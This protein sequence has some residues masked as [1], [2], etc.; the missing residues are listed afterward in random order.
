MITPHSSV[1]VDIWH[2]LNVCV[3]PKF[4]YWNSNPN[5]TVLGGG[6]FAKSL[7]HENGVLMNGISALIEDHPELPLPHEDI[8]R[9]CNQEEGPRL[10]MLVPGSWTC[11]LQNCEEWISI[12]Y[13]LPSLWYLLQQPSW[14]KTT[15]ITYSYFDMALNIQ[16]LI[17]W[18]PR[19]RIDD[20]RWIGSGT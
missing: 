18:G 16:G 8:V 7:S 11:S 13:K 4:R 6:D 19:E 1:P 10:T 14:T 2:G 15:S 9:H 17:F 20:Q 12:V 3:P 5:V